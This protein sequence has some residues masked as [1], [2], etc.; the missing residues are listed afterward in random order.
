MAGIGLSQY[1]NVFR[2]EKID[3]DSLMLLEEED[4]LKMNI[5]TGPR[6]KILNKVMNTKA[7]IIWLG[8]RL[9]LIC[10]CQIRE[11]KAAMETDM[12]LEDSKL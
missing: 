9:T 1:I 7:A 2:R 5:E 12:P 8:N 6:K 10:I 11:R 4:L 3:L